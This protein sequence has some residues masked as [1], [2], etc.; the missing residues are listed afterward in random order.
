MLGS[1]TMLLYGAHAALEHLL[2]QGSSRIIG[3][4]AVGGRIRQ[5]GRVVFNSCR[6]DVVG[7]TRPGTSPGTRSP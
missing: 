7:F 6:S 3:I 2:R 5:R 1:P 4:G